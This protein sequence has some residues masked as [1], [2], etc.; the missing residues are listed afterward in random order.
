MYL[1]KI[2][3]NDDRKIELEIEDKDLDAFV[4]SLQQ[5][6]PYFNNKDG[7]GFWLPPENVRYAWI[8]KKEEHPQEPCQK[9]VNLEAEEA[10]VS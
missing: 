7:V 1:Y 5:K 10:S 9:I 6:K 3:F 2:T 4:F 8:Y